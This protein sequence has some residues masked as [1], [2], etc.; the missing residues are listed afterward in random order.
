MLACLPNL[1]REDAV[2]DL[3]VL[4]GP[5]AGARFPIPDVPVAVGRSLEANV[6]I[7]DPWVS[8]I[9]ALIERRGAELW[10]VD[11]ESRNGTFVDDLPV[12]EARL[13]PGMSLAF[14]QTRL[15]LQVRD[16]TTPVDTKAMKT[17]FRRPHLSITAPQAASPR[18]GGPPVEPDKD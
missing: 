3:V 2:V 7:D 14:G 15:E 17:P 12:T 6:Q 11:L 5:C 18:P 16:A 10:V 1:P 9:H 13:E 8:N 4:N